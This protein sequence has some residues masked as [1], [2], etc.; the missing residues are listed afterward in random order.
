M[1]HEVLRDAI[2]GIIKKDPHRLPASTACCSEPPGKWSAMATRGNVLA[3]RDR[4]FGNQMMPVKADQP[5]ES[6][7]HLTSQGSLNTAPEK[8]P[9]PSV[10]PMGT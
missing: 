9:P 4:L 2:V 5:V 3:I 6:F 1:R 7:D 8:G 10:A